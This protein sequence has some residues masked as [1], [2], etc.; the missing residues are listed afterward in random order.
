MEGVVANSLGVHLRAN[1][2]QYGVSPQANE[3]VYQL[4]LQAY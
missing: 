2:G 3:H 1:L 4:E